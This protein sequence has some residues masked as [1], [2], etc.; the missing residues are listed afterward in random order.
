[1]EARQLIG[2]ASFGPDKLKTLFRA[3]DDAWNDIAANF[4]ENRLAI[5]AAR[6]KL[7]NVVL[8]VAQTEGS[9]SD[10][11]QI[12]NAALQ[13]MAKDARTGAN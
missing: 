5:E 12:K 9:D 2:S 8:A 3:F 1:V 10:P 4:G 11:M 6:L 7:A 13:I